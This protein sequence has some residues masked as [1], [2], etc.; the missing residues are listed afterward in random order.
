KRNSAKGNVR[1]TPK[2]RHV[3][4]NGSCLLW[5]K[6][7][8]SVKNSLSAMRSPRRRSAGVKNVRV[9]AHATSQRTADKQI[10]ATGSFKCVTPS[11]EQDIPR[12]MVRITSEGHKIKLLNGNRPEETR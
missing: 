6:S 9:H 5:A 12:W 3:Q 10:A 4:C 1:F 11:I 8:H 2:S 7:G